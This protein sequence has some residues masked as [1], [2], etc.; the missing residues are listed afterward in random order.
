[1]NYRVAMNIEAFAN[2]VTMVM[3]M[4]GI[5]HRHSYLDFFLRESVAKIKYATPPV[6][7]TQITPDKPTLTLSLSIPFT[8]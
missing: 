8:P 1:M 6:M 2:V 3:T 4:V 5:H 7:I